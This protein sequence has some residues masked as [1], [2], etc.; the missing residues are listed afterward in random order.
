MR[1]TLSL[2]YGLTAYLLF[3]GTFLYA[4]G[5]ITGWIV[6]K[7]I[8]SGPVAPLWEALLVN[9]LLLG[10]FAVQ[11]SG[12]AR[13]QFKV[14]LTGWMSPAIER[15]TFVLLSSLVLILLFWQWRPIPT[16]VWSVPVPA[17]AVAVQALS[18]IGIVIV[19]VSTFLINHFELFGLHQVVNNYLGRTMPEP[20][21]KHPSLYKLVRHPI[22]FG[23]IVAFWSA[24][25]MTVGH[26]MFAA[27]TTAYI[28]I[29]IWLEERDL[30]AQFG[31]DYRRYRASVPMLIPYAGRLKEDTSVPRQAAS[32][33]QGRSS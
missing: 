11:H 19:L 9:T 21:F 17:I 3:L 7:H 23:F 4:V 14:W 1:R 8:D 29:G 13:R 6:P 10:L 2:L 25:V 15:S 24:P 22:Y 31:D 30:V 20:S 32:A 12:M 18:L 27:A 5:F 28:L 26:L 33:G 16:V